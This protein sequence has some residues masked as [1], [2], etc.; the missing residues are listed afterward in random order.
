MKY[1]AIKIFL[2]IIAVL[3][4]AILVFGPGIAINKLEK[5]SKEWVGRKLEIGDYS[6]NYFTGTV[7][8]NNFVMYEA[9]DKTPFV[10]FDTLL[11]NTEPFRLFS[12]ELVIE[13]I[14]LIGLQTNIIKNDSIFN[15]DDLIAF[16]NQPTDS[17]ATVKKE[18]ADTTSNNDPMVIKVSNIHMNAKELSYS[19]IQ[20]K[21]ETKIVHLNIVVPYISWNTDGGSHAGIQFDLADNGHFLIDF[22]LN[23]NSND[24]HTDINIDDL[25]LE[26]Y[27]VYAEQQLNISALQGMFSTNL[28]IDGTLDAIEKTLVSG[29]IN[30]NDFA[31]HDLNNQKLLGVGQLTVGIAKIDNF[32]NRFIIDSVRIS[33][34]FVDFELFADGTNFSNFIK[35]EF[36]SLGNINKIETQNDT[37]INQDVN[38]S[39]IVKS[40]AI[41]NG[42]IE[43][44][45][46]TTPELFEYHLSD[47]NMSA[48]AISSDADW[49]I[50]YLDMLLNKRGKMKV[51]LGFNPMKPLDLDL[52]YVLTNFQ[53]SDINIYSEV[54][55][56]YPFVYG[57]MF[58]TSNTKIRNGIIESENNLRIND[59]ELGE[60]VKGIKSI[61]IKFALFL[62]KD[63]NGDVVLDVPVRGDLNDPEINIKKLV[64]TTLKN[65]IFKIVS[66]PVDFLAGFAKVDPKDIKT[67]EFA[68]LD[69]TLNNRVEH[70]L[71]M[72]LK[73]ENKKPGL[74]I[75]MAYFNDIEKEKDAIAID[76]TG[77]I[78]YQKKKK[79]YKKEIDAFKKFIKK[80]TQK[81]SM[82]IVSD[83]RELTGI[84]VVDSL[85]SAY[86]E[87]RFLKIDSY[88]RS[89]NDSTT[90]SIV[91]LNPDSPKNI[92]S[93]PKFEM[94][95][96]VND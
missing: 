75:E 19:D 10:A 73:L 27:Y 20:L 92:G 4:V 6:L 52:Y 90:I 30:L 43:F 95:Y 88:L 32:N 8:I 42:V 35:Q 17:I 87:L 56:G 33:N 41:D 54:S 40:F 26:T 55:T 85:Y 61:P 48:E 64:W 63:K 11:I 50:T 51:E 89:K 74:K 53:L 47:I 21:H 80:R 9:D 60:K 58:Y 12:N 69:T 7:E 62:L 93:I 72:L 15:F 67:I 22:D 31:V 3:I 59:V 5:N 70:Q 83:C 44:K 79:D 91:P 65:A 46:H 81:D 86:S 18:P 14:A 36:D 45:D 24:F 96:S 34:P 29:K 68:Y 1:K 39:Y 25:N 23:P 16:Y 94:K 49:V 13:E 82:D 84:Q 66:A 76:E 77:K 78:F 71:D 38:L 37:V 28:N 2:F 57:E